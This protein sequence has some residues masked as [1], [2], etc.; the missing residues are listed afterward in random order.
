MSH[1]I[2]KLKKGFPYLDSSVGFDQSEKALEALL[3]KFGCSR[4]GM[5]KDFRGDVPLLTLLFEKDGIAYVI[6]FPVTYYPKDKLNMNISGR[7]V[8]YKVKALLVD[9]EIGIL[10]F[11]QAMSPLREGIRMLKEAGIRVARD[12]I[13][14]YVLVGPQHTTPKEDVER[15]RILKSLGVQPYVMPFVSNPW[16]RKL[17]W[18][19]RPRVFWTC[20]IDEMDRQRYRSD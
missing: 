11:L 12:T 18:W 6:P 20:D 5:S 9:A 4:I 16:T 3:Q 10:T 2:V 19:A 14:V 8:Y 15:L 1:A 7:I 13:S 17:R